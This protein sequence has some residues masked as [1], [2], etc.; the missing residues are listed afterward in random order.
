[1]EERKLLARLRAVKY[2]LKE[3]FNAIAAIS[4]LDA[5]V[6]CMYEEKKCR[7]LYRRSSGRGSADNYHGLVN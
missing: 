4:V 5:I 6:A 3:K 7:R 2:F 1:M